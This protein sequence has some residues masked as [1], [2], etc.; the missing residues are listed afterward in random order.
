MKQRCLTNHFYINAEITQLGLKMITFFKLCSFPRRV[1][2]EEICF[3]KMIP[4]VAPGSLVQES[5][6]ARAELGIF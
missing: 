2:Q 4:N 3:Q 1:F 5:R 6:G